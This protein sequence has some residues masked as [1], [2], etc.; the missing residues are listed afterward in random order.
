VEFTGT[1]SIGGDLLITGNTFT[2]HNH[3]RHRTTM[4]TSRPLNLPITNDIINQVKNNQ[5]PTLNLNQQGIVVPVI[6]SRNLYRPSSSVPTLGNTPMGLIVDPLM[7][8]NQNEVGFHVQRQLHQHTGFPIS[9]YELIRNTRNLERTTLTYS[10]L[11][12]LDTSIA[13]YTYLTINLVSY[14][15]ISISHQRTETPTAPQATLL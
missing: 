9:L 8:L 2:S 7:Q 5:N 12:T 4:D 1:Q 10:D 3:D 11:E 15:F 13:Y 14:R 6:P